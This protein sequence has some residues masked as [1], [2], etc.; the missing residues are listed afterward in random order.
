MVVRGTQ[1][2]ELK[3]TRIGTPYRFRERAYMTCTHYRMLK[4]MVLVTAVKER[5]L[6]TLHHGRLQQLFQTS[7]YPRLIYQNA[8]I[9]NIAL[10]SPPINLE[11]AFDVLHLKQFPPSQ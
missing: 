8:I 3:T 6:N 1:D 10:P 4:E 7:P 5:P 11:F 2:A 9:S